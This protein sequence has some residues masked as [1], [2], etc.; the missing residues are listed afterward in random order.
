MEHPLAT[1]MGPAQQRDPLTTGQDYWRPARLSG[2]EGWHSGYSPH[3]YELVTLPG[4]VKKCYGCEAEFTE[5]YRNSPNNIV[6]KHVDRRLVRKDEHKG[7][8]LYSADYSNTYCHLD[9]ADIQ[10]KNPTFNGEVFISYDKLRF[11]FDYAQCDMIENC[12]VVFCILVIL[13]SHTLT[14]DYSKISLYI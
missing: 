8:F 10:R 13:V 1:L 9:F 7:H 4:N 14:A 5:R 3:R 11:G 2:A 12:N 6:I